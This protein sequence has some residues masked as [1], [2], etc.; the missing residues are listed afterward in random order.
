MAAGNCKRA[1]GRAGLGRGHAIDASS[2]E[3][4]ALGGYAVGAVSTIG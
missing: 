3:C 1:R 4:T 2:F